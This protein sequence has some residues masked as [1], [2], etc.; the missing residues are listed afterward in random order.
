MNLRRLLP[1]AVGLFAMAGHASA[2]PF[3]N[4]SNRGSRMGDAANWGIIAM[5]II[6]FMMLGAV[7]A[8]GF[9]LRWRAKN[10]LPDY[11][12]LLDDTATSHPAP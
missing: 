8:F 7:A 10:P 3:C 11:S 12:D 4:A 5:T 6:M 9:Y 2:C 1:L